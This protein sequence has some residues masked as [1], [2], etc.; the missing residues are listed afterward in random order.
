MQ[1]RA[2]APAHRF[3][4]KSSRAK[5]L[6]AVHHDRRLG[7]VAVVVEAASVARDLE[8]EVLPRVRRRVAVVAVL[9]RRASV[10]AGA[11]AARRSARRGVIAVVVAV[12]AERA[13][14]QL[15][16]ARVAVVA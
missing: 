1:A 16:G 14:E 12:G 15:V 7:A 4:T 9:Q 3:F 6:L 8:E 13:G 5:A 10:G 2:S 11:T